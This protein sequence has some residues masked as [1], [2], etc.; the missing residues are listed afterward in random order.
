MKKFVS[1]VGFALVLL[2]ILATNAMCT[3]TGTRG[4]CPDVASTSALMGIACLGL[5]GARKFLRR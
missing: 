5:A 3:G 2:A 4:N 1:N